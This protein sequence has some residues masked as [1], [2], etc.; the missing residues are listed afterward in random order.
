MFIGSRIHHHSTTDRAGDTRRKS[1]AA[2]SFPG[3]KCRH[4]GEQGSSLG[5]KAVTLTPDGSHRLPETDHKPTNPAVGNNDVGS[6]AQY[7]DRQAVLTS[8]P[9]DGG[10]FGR[11]CWFNEKVS[12]TTHAECG[13]A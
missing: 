5:D 4:T 1:E 13:V 11:R 3:C 6:I 2:Q 12:R 10:K 9:E 7:G 8:H